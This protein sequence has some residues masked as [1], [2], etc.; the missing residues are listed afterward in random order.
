MPSLLNVRSS[1]LTN[2]TSK[3]QTYNEHVLVETP[4]ASLPS[5]A[6]LLVAIAGVPASGKTTFAV[7]LVQHVNTLVGARAS[8]ARAILVGL[9]GWHLARAQLDA[10]DDPRHAHDRR[11]SH[12]TFDAPAYLDF[13]ARL[14]SPIH[15]A[16]NIIYAPS[17]DHAV[18]DPTPDAVAL[19]PAH[20]IV[21]IEGLYT[22]L[23]VEPW[24]DAAAQMDERWWIDI[25]VMRARSRL[26]RRHIQTGVAR[27]TVEAIWRA[28]NNDE[29]SE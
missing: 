28:E 15:S 4:S 3:Y 27:D 29:D 20:R 16:T 7:R 24:R 1:S 21:V 11:G 5:T 12:W 17:F 14:R 18:K 19:T 6:R 25:D 23:D 9:D 10:M 13:V 8:P 26:V 2:S 22:M